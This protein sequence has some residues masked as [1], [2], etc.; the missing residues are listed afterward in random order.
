[1]AASR[2]KLLLIDGH[3]VLH[4]AWHALPPLTTK[5][6]LVV[7]GAYGFMMLLLRSIKDIAPTHVAVTFD[8][9]GPTFRHEAYEAYKA[10]RE[11]QADE[12]YAQIPMIEEILKAMDVP[13]YG[14]K[15]V[16]ADDVIGTIARTVEKKTKDV[17]VVIVTGDKDILQLVTDRVSVYHLRK[18][19]SDMK[20]Y[21]PAD[22]RERFGFDPL[23]M[24]DYKAL[25]GDPSD[26]IPGVKGVGEK[27]ATA[28]VQEFGSVEA[29]YAALD[30]NAPAFTA[31]KPAV[32]K[33]LAASRKDA[34]DAL[35]LCTILTDVDVDFSLEDTEYSV[36][37][38]SAVRA[39][40]LKYEFAKLLTQFPGGSDAI[41]DDEKS[42]VPS[43]AKR[44][45]VKDDPSSV[46][47]LPLAPRPAE[48]EASS[49]DDIRSVLERFVKSGSFSFRSVRTGSRS[50]PEIAACAFTDGKTTLTVDGALVK[51]ALP[52]I[53]ATLGSPATKD[54]HDLKAEVEAF[55]A[56]GIVIAEPAFDAMIGFYLLHSG[57]RK[58]ELSSMMTYFR[59]P[60]AGE[61]ASAAAQ[62]SAEVNAIHRVAKE[63]R[64]EIHANS[65]DT[66]YA[67]IDGPLARVLAR[68]E[69][70]GVAVDV[71][72]LEKLSKDLEQRIDGLTSKIH[73]F[74]GREFNI[75]SPA[76]LQVV[77][78]DELG[79]SSERMK[80]TAKS[81]TISTAAAE[82]I[83]I[84]D[85]HGIIDAILDY[86]EFTKLKSTYVDALPPLV[87]PGS[88]RIHA[89]FNQTVAATGRLSSSNP[90]LQNIP[91]A[92]TEYGK[93]VRDAFVAEK[94]FTLIAADYSQ[95]ELRLAAHMTGEKVM[96]EAFKNGEDI[97]WRTA[98]TMF[99]EARAEETRRIAKVINFGIL[100]GMGAMRL[101][102]AAKITFAE[103]KDYIDTYFAKH[104]GIAKYMEEMRQK[105][106]TDEYVETLFGRKRFFRNV[107]LMNPRELAEAE[108]QGIN[109]PMQGTQADMIKIAML[110]IDKELV[111]AYGDAPDGPVRMVSQVHDELI[112][113]VADHLVEEVLPIVV[114][115]MEGV[116]KLK[117]PVKVDVATG[118]RWGSMD[119]R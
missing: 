118:K 67:E 103:A 112:F 79:L 15:G 47:Q 7:S 96:I 3:A 86:R 49:A 43:P 74:A 97:H 31:L 116:V 34:F 106:H 53:A 114:K 89:E 32:Q 37:D 24:I 33:N 80:K 64:E 57:E 81:R 10:Q 21:A 11:E 51:A 54:C 59:T 83:K 76:Q 40:F 115:N 23:Q 92:D 26:N 46:A 48:T 36:P 85:Q 71:P 88:E 105:V 95:I 41:A 22:V 29:I 108:R 8:M 1:M 19:V 60:G 109:M 69:R 55:A 39:P 73:G 42:R 5:D 98:A 107:H 28:L 78:F 70:A 84:R 50:A 45:T 111:K 102:E 101:A 14:V 72:Y 94:G 63:L 58:S 38:Q 87:D 119:T 93:K 25:A 56:N 75:N 65:L 6:G 110:R 9:E 35:K 77:L 117:V 100:Y 82:L 17:D 16:E 27:T 13:V 104:P 90:N 62:L 2:K 68:M 12:L 66:L 44:A 4:R 30:K 113:E 61:D 91:T 18:G 99:G 20:M 52:H